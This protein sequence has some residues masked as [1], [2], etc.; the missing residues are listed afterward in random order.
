M[1]HVALPL[2]K[3]VPP[4]GG[5]VRGHHQCQGGEGV[6]GRVVTL[7]CGTDA[8]EFPHLEGF[9]QLAVGDSTEKAWKEGGGGKEGG[10]EGGREGGK[11]GVREVGR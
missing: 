3:A 8:G 2:H 4:R 1:H 10:R 9:G 6:R 11:E 7:D 5:E